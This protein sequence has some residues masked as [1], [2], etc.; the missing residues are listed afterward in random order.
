[1]KQ[2]A[3]AGIRARTKASGKRFGCL[4]ALNNEQKKTVME[5][6]CMRITVSA[7]AREFS[8]TWQTIMSLRDNKAM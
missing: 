3:L 7:V 1:M 8:T 5:R 6:L 4:S 2:L